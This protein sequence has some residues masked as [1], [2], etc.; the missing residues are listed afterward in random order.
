MRD[1]I[2]E[3]YTGQEC[4]DQ[5]R[6]HH[7][8]VVTDDDGYSDVFVGGNHQDYRGLL[9]VSIEEYFARLL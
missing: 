8:A 3:A 4:T 5:G 2:Q 1:Q 7:T 9:H 6:D